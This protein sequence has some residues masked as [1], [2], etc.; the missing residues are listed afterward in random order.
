MKKSGRIDIG[1]CQPFA[2]IGAYFGD[3]F[4]DANSHIF[5]SVMKA[6][7][8]L[9]NDCSFFQ[10]ILITLFLGTVGLGLATDLFKQVI[11]SFFKYGIPGSG[12]APASAS[13][14]SGSANGSQVQEITMDVLRK[15]V[16]QNHELMSHIL[17]QNK[18]ALSATE[19]ITTLQTTTETPEETRNNSD[20]ESIEVI[21]EKSDNESENEFEVIKE[22]IG[23]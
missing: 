3:L 6:Y 21:P 7:R 12:R 2:V 17:S 16:E 23:S 20:T 15:T 18:P 14:D 11:A 10:S 5:G 22:S 1:M 8:D 19:I 9:I 4:V 13:L